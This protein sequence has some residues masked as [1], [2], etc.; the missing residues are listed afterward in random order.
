M[1]K[2]EPICA[3]CLIHRGVEEA[4]LATNDPA[5]EMKVVK[6][7]LEML[8]E[9]FTVEAVPAKLGAE[10]DRVVREVTK[11]PDPY[12]GIKMMSNQ[13][14]LRVLPIAERRVKE[15]RP[16]LE[17]FRVACAMAAAANAFEFGVL[18]YSFNVEEAAR[19]ILEAEI[20]VDDSEEAYGYVKPGA[21]VLYLADNAG[22]IGFDKLL[23]EVLKELGAKVRLVVKGSPIL[24]DA[25]VEDARFFNLEALVDELLTTPGDEVGLD[26]S[27]ITGRLRRAYDEASLIIAKGM[28]HYETLTEHV[29]KPPVLHVLKAKCAP[30]ARSLGVKRGSLVVKLRREQ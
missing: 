24:N 27:T 12:R 26:P 7:L 29:A 25:L 17:R 19:A 14:A 18:G 10:R 2:V 13:E 23:V 15:A 20:E 22:E 4:K 1:V 11:C 21:E 16:G 6:Q 3:A 8:R 9:S 5:V 28:G 30:I